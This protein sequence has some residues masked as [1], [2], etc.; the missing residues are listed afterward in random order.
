MKGFLPPLA[1]SKHQTN[2]ADV[3]S[4]LSDGELEGI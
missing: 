1:P 4:L 3:Y 2:T